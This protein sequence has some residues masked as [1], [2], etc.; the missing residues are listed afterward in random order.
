MLA[1]KPS[2]L[3]RQV[4]QM[5]A[6]S[7]VTKLNTQKMGLSYPNHS[8]G[9]ISCSVG[10]SNASGVFWGLAGHTFGATPPQSPMRSWRRWV[11]KSNLPEE[12]LRLL[13]TPKLQRQLLL[14]RL[15]RLLQVST[16][17]LPSLTLFF[18]TFGNCDT[19]LQT[20]TGAHPSSSRHSSRPS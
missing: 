15:L 11:S 19:Y 8:D 7:K 9:V 17:S 10:C 16:Q 5:P 6:L 1:G 4:M 12:T 3:G 13:I 20:V 14:I 2:P 18:S